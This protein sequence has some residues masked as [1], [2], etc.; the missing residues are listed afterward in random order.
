MYW[1]FIS[2]QYEGGGYGPVIDIFVETEDIEKANRLIRENK[3]NIKEF[4]E[5]SVQEEYMYPVSHPSFNYKIQNRSDVREILLDASSPNYAICGD[6]TVFWMK[7]Y[8]T[9]VEL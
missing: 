4:R 7:Y 5:H 3:E 2:C 8:N 1:S 9:V 6:G